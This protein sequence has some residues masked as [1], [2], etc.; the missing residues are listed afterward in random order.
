[1]P[2]LTELGKR[3]AIT[4]QRRWNDD[5]NIIWIPVSRKIAL[6]A[7]SVAAAIITMCLLP[8]S[9]NNYTQTIQPRFASFMSLIDRPAPKII[10]LNAKKEKIAQPL[11]SQEAKVEEVRQEPAKTPAVWSA[12]RY[13]IIVA[14]FSTGTAADIEIRRFV[15]RGFNS[16]F[17][18]RS[19]DRHRICIASFADRQEAETFLQKFR[20]ESPQYSKAWLLVDN[21]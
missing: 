17:V 15:D 11:P 7:A 9:L 19:R 6:Y 18:H 12:H 5:D 8:S 20:K 3:S 16:V 21:G 13:F 1:L 10:V 2:L 14:S 4:S